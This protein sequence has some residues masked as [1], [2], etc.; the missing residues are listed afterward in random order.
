MGWKGVVNIFKYLQE[1]QTEKEFNLC[2]QPQRDSLVKKTRKWLS[3]EGNE[4][5]DN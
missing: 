4:F 5:S 2:C 1:N 3:G